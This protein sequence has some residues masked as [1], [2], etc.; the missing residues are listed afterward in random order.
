MNWIIPSSLY[1]PWKD[2]SIELETDLTLQTGL[3][4]Q[5]KGDNGSGKT[6][7]I[8]KI[9]IPQLLKKPEEQYI[10]YI[11]QQVQSQ[12]DAVK[13]Y[14][15][16]QKPAKHITNTE[17]MISFYFE[18]LTRK[19]EQESR[20]VVLILDECILPEAVNTQLMKLEKYGLCLIYIAHQD[21]SFKTEMK[22]AEFLFKQIDQH[23]SLLVIP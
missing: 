23:K 3:I 4:Y 21:Y 7:F 10:L 2:F 14:A 6:S 9:L 22:K 19:L 13:S 1:N 17:E 18:I 15:A 8:K 11:E 12:F 5:L 20:E 16:L